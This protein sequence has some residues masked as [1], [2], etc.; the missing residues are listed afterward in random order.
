MFKVL[1]IWLQSNLHYTTFRQ[2]CV[3]RHGKTVQWRTQDLNHGFKIT[4]QMLFI[5]QRVKR[6]TREN[7]GR[8]ILSYNFTLF[9]QF[10]SKFRSHSSQISTKFK[11][12][13]LETVEQVW[14]VWGRL[15]PLQGVCGGRGEGGLRL[16]YFLIK[17]FCIGDTPGNTAGLRLSLIFKWFDFCLGTL[18]IIC[19]FVNKHNQHCEY[20]QVCFR[21]LWFMVI[22][23]TCPCLQL[24]RGLQLY[25]RP[26]RTFTR[27]GVA[28][29]KDLWSMNKVSET[30]CNTFR[31]KRKILQCSVFL[32]EKEKNMI[33]G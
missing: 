27:C 3:Q 4:A 9:A 2:L 18:L 16:K 26:N 11:Q 25:Y 23:E 29:I 31:K 17:Q 12:T 21:G 33:S 1:N 10:G 22:G 19:Y 15:G 13:Q 24:A 6:S 28:L 20:T 8:C 32:H 30:S 5:V 14:W 7:C